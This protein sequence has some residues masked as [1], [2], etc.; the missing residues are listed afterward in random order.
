M[1]RSAFKLAKIMSL[2]L[3][4]KNAWPLGGDVLP[5]TTLPDQV[6]KSLTREHTP[7][8]QEVL[9]PITATPEKQGSPL[10]PQAEKITFQLNGIVLEGNHIYTTSQLEPLYRDKLHKTISVADLFNIVQSITN[11]Y[12]NNGYIISRA[13]LPPQ[14]VKNGMVQVQVIEGF[15]DKVDV[16]GHP[17]GAQCLA[18]AYGEKIKACPPLEIKRMEYYLL[19]ANEI[20][21]TTVKAV[22]SPSKTKTGAAD[23]TLVTENKPITGYASYDDYGTRYIGPQQMT[24]NV[25][26]N[27][28]AASG[29]STQFTFTKTPKGGELTYYDVNYNLPIQ[30]TGVRATFG[31]TRTQTH[32]LFVLQPAQIDGLTNNYYTMVQYPILRSRTQNL[33]LRTG[34]NYL[35]SSVT[36]FSQ[37][38][39]TDHLRSLDLGGT[40]NFAD[41]FY[42]AN[43][44]SSDVRQGLP[45]FGATHQDD[46]TT[47]QTS[48]PG[49][50][51]NYTKITLQLSRLQAIR[52]PVSLYGLFSGQWAFNPLLASEQFSFGGPQLGRGYDVAEIIG[53]RG[54]AGSL[55]LRY[56]WPVQKFKIENLQ[57]Y[58]FYDAGEVWNIQDIP[59]TQKKVSGTST[60]IGMRFYITQYVS[61]NVMWTQ[62]LTKQV[63]AEELIGE[64]RRPRMFFSLVASWA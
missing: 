58:V 39:Y 15:I 43:L 61:G 18:K 35:D 50:R 34:F 60:G 8:Q 36:T 52:G 37:K 12:R 16:S 32:P 56:D 42:G 22:L 14:H 53:D 20:P 1:K 10:G 57:F 25:A 4:A 29:D 28:M 46:P 45:L 17:R 48:H 55:E 3:L 40:Y 44:I 62:T 5:A 7:Q 64:G 38:L 59:G 27:S 13:I 49:G 6:G 26:V 51:G 47:A 31:D 63:A 11:Y 30:D 19:L 54:A 9:P 24:G 41:R 2:L 21:A 23:L 33:T